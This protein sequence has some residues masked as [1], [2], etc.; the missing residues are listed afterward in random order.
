MVHLAT[1]TLAFIIAGLALPS[2][3][4]YNT[5]M[6]SQQY[7]GHD[8]KLQESITNMFQQ[9]DNDDDIVDINIIIQ[10]NK[11]SVPFKS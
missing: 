6:A 4:F 7:Y 10:F 5:L 8:I 1:A 2:H 11:D 3:C 9:T